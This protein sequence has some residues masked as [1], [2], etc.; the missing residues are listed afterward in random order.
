MGER[1]RQDAMPL[2]M[3]SLRFSLTPC[4]A[5]FMAARVTRQDIRYALTHDDDARFD[6]A[7]HSYRRDADATRYAID[8]IDTPRCRRHFA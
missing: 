5:I 3:P 7:S 4:Y 1:C 8:A 2:L 6:S